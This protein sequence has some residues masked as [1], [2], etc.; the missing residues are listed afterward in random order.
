MNDINSIHR[1][2]TYA[3]MESPDSLNE[4]YY[5]DRKANEFFSIF[6]TDYYVL[7]PQDPVYEQ[8][9]YSDVEKK[10]M[11]RK[12]KRVE[13][14]DPAMLRVSRLSM[15]ERKGLMQDFLNM[16][17]LQHESSLQNLVDEL[18]D[19]SPL[20]FKDLLSPELEDEWR[21]FKSEFFQLKI[22]SFCNLN[23]IDLETATLFTDK[24]ITSVSLKID[25]DPV[26]DLKKSVK[27]KK[28]WW[29]FW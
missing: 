23:G 8:L 15:E 25:D 20:E 5:F 27:T 17:H 12:I 29:K 13:A 24:K 1:W 22:D 18:D 21:Y 28:P 7:Y 14:K 9:P 10:I 2:L 19:R 11:A 6:L 3:F 16:H 26:P 4:I